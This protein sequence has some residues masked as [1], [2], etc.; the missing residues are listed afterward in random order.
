MMSG[1][2]GVGLGLVAGVDAAQQVAE[3]GAGELPVERPGDG[4][5]AGLE[6]GIATIQVPPA[7]LSLT[8]SGSPNP[9][10]S[11]QQLTYT[12][13]AINTGGQT[14]TCVTVTDPLPDTVHFGS[15]ST[16]QG[17]CTHTL[18][19]S[20]TKDGAVTCSI[21]DLA[22]GGQA[23]VTIVVRTTR[24]GTLTDTATVTASNITPSDADDSATAIVTVL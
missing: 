12:I 17:T 2:Q 14:A 19:T 9:V 8:N 13:T 1:C 15:V 10:A 6:R 4:V 3:V 7:D 22:A 24:T 11:G 18:G 16:T 20:K 21:G 5:I 23:E